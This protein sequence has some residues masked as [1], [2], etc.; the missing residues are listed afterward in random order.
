MSIETV[1][2]EPKKNPAGGCA[3]GCASIFVFIGLLFPF[4]HMLGG[5]WEGGEMM[6]LPM[7]I[8][9]PSF[10][11]GN[12]LAIVALC[13]SAPSTRRAG[14]RALLLIWSSLILICGISFIVDTFFR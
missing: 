5:T 4:L 9:V 2:H 3:I 14:K 10:L 6:V 11:I 7:L 8:G 12:I 1:I 13:S